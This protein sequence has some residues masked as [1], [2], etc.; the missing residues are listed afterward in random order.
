MAMTRK[1]AATRIQRAYRRRRVANRMRRYRKKQAY[2]GRAVNTRSTQP[3]FVETFRGAAYGRSESD[4]FDKVLTV[5]VGGSLGAVFKVRITDI[6]Q[7]NQYS[8][9]Y[10]Q[11]RINWIK[12]FLIPS[13]N[14]DAADIN[15]AAFNAVPATQISGQGTGRISW[16]V[17]DSPNEWSPLTEDEVLQDNGCKFKTIGKRWSQSFKPVPDVEMVTTAGNIYTRQKYRQWFNFGELSGNNPLHGAVTA[18]INLPG[19]SYPGPSMLSSVENYHIYY[20]VSFTL[21]DPR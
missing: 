4:R 6:P 18:F 17:Q 21:R 15:A 14:G 5:P 3:T 20:K 10:T 1:Y 19:I 9:L 2:V 8:D 12:V 11:Y 16:S 13:F 7:V